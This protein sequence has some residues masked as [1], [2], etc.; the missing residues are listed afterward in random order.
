VRR[1][2]RDVYCQQA[3]NDLTKRVADWLKEWDLTTLEELTLLNHV[4]SGTIGGTL[5][6]CIREER[7][8]D[9]DKEGGLVHEEE[10]DEGD[11]G[12]GAKHRR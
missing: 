2:P 3:G 9:P 5:K 7:H 12:G 6:Y 10:T 8:G 4:L 1:H 11:D